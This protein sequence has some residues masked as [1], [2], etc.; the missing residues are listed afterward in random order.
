MSSVTTSDVSACS[1][2]FLLATSAGA[3]DERAVMMTSSR[4][5]VAAEA[6]DCSEDRERRWFRRTL[7]WGT[8]TAVPN[9]DNKP[10]GE[11][12]DHQRR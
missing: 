2:T 8:R 10:V 7:S 9:R 11:Q 3:K 5:S 1:V 6:A 12:K 4:V